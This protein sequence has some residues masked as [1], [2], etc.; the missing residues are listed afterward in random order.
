MWVALVF[1][2]I[3]IHHIT[4]RAV[5]RTRPSWMEDDDYR[6]HNFN[7][8]YRRVK[9]PSEVAFETV[10]MKEVAP[11]SL[12]DNGYED[13][14]DDDEEALPVIKPLPTYEWIRTTRTSPFNGFA[15]GQLLEFLD[16]T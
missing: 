1:W 7:G 6:K 13:E 8:E 12:D 11:D 16:L 14:F 5:A 9:L 3:L 4:H 2:I 10:E 15:V